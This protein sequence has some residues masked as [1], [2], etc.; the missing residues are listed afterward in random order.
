[1]EILSSPIKQNETTPR[2]EKNHITISPYQLSQA[3]LF[4]GI[5]E[6][7]QKRSIEK[8][9]ALGGALNDHER[10]VLD[11]LSCMVM[12]NAGD[13]SI[14]VKNNLKGLEDIALYLGN[15][16]AAKIINKIGQ[17]ADMRI[18]GSSDIS[19]EKNFSK[20][21]LLAQVTFSHCGNNL[22]EQIEDFFTNS[23]G[24]MFFVQ[25][26]KPTQDYM[27]EI[28]KANGNGHNGLTINNKI[29]QALAFPSDA[30]RQASH[31]FT[32]VNFT[33]PEAAKQSQTE[34]NHFT[35]IL[36]RRIDEHI[37]G[38]YAH[39]VLLRSLLAK[40]MQAALISMTS[41]TVTLPFLYYLNQN[42]G[43]DRF[44]E[45]ALIKFI[46]PV[47]SDLVTFYSQLKPWLEGD[48]FGQEMVDFGK[49]LIGS[50]RKSA[51][52]SLIATSTGSALAEA[53]GSE[54]GN[55]PGAVI[56]SLIP[57]AVAMLTTWDTLQMIKRK[58]DKPFLKVIKETFS[59]NPAQLSIDTASL[60]TFFTGVGVL[61]IGN[62]F[63]NPTA[64]AFVEGVEEHS[65]AAVFTHL[66]LQFG[67]SLQFNAWAKKEVDLWLKKHPLST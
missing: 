8:F 58:T 37:E 19:S 30:I 10:Q 36:N 5:S 7:N 33:P 66:Q 18:I 61:G 21:P 13:E 39:L 46:P 25:F 65:L 31:Q 62:Q 48:N 4:Y 49:K 54:Y 41:L 64:I 3:F 45:Q 60:I 38:D 55:L 59:N 51:L 44:V 11:D 15:N 2:K 42:S 47:L 16:E 23:G 1:M 34:A 24:V 17:V 29:N 28:G 22:L 67:V 12:S 53:L 50:H 43:G 57:F 6:R 14:S 40:E 63:H 52:A 26:K 35:A 20:L 56:Y 32:T 9:A 27:K